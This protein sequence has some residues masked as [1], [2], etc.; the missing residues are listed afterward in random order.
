MRIVQSAL[1]VAATM[2]VAGPDSA[3]AQQTYPNRSVQLVV[4]VRAVLLLARDLGRGCS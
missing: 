4:P 1:L 3:A 2:M